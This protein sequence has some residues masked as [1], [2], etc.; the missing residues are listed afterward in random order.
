MFALLAVL[1]NVAIAA[2][3]AQTPAVFNTSGILFNQ[4]LSSG[5]GTSGP[6][7]CSVDP[8]GNL[9]C[10]ESPGVSHIGDQSLGAQN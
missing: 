10:Y 5:C 8:P 9:C 3:S 2:V 4:G 1:T 6:P 7:S